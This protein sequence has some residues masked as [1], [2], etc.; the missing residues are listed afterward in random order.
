[1]E[2]TFDYKLHHKIPAYTKKEAIKKA[3]A[4]MRKKSKRG[5]WWSAVVKCPRDVKKNR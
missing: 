5:V 3:R 2:C 1:M 4:L